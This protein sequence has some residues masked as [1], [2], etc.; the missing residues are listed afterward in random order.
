MENREYIELST[1]ST[2]D[3]FTINGCGKFNSEKIHL[4]SI[5]ATLLYI[6]LHNWLTK[7]KHET[8]GK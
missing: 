5:E 3:K 1:I 7:Q 4:S 2:K 8:N 6:D